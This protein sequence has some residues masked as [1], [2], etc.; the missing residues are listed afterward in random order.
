MRSIKRYYHSLKEAFMSYLKANQVLPAQVIELIQEYVEG[1]T[2]YIPKKAE[3]KLTWG[4]K[5][6]SKEEVLNRNQNIYQ[7]YLDGAKVGELAERYF[8]STKSI[9]RILGEVK[10]LEPASK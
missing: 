7:E 5:T 9:Y 6:Q 8:L 3:N 2:L 4:T 1:Q 10:A